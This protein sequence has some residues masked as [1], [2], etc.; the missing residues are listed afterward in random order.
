MFYWVLIRRTSTT[1]FCH[2]SVSLVICSVFLFTGVNVGNRRTYFYALPDATDATI[3]YRLNTRDTIKHVLESGSHELF[4]I[5]STT[6]VIPSEAS[7][8]RAVTSKGWADPRSLT[9]DIGAD[10]I[11][12]KTSTMLNDVDADEHVA[13]P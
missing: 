2:G 5:R 9:V 3:L 1:L 8:R 13:L 10:D 6:T 7:S 11:N 12:T 4:G